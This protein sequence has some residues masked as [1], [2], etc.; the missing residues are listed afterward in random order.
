MEYKLPIDKFIIDPK[1]S[2]TF[3][4]MRKMT[5][6]KLH[7]GYTCFCNVF[8]IFVSDREIN[9]ERSKVLQKFAGINNSQKL[10][11]MNLPLLQYT[12]NNF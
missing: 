5:I 8:M 10:Y 6:N 4:L 7:T 3:K 11:D 1:E 2:E 12:Q 9:C